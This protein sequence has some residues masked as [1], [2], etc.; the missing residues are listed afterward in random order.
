[1]D[2]SVEPGRPPPWVP[3]AVSR[4]APSVRAGGRSEDQQGRPRCLGS[5]L[6]LIGLPLPLRGATDAPGRGAWRPRRL[7]K[8]ESRSWA[9]LREPRRAP[10]APAS[11]RPRPRLAS[12]PPP[13]EAPGEAPNTVPRCPGSQGTGKGPCL[14]LHGLLEPPRQVSGPRTAGTSL[15]DFRKG[16]TPQVSGQIGSQTGGF[17]FY[18]RCFPCVSETSSE[19]QILR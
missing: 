19:F 10:H 2:G 18:L 12:T 15:R 6:S 3:R 7:R 11:V 17:H 4:G 14:G 9:G 8:A 16:R 13:P 5:A 1:M